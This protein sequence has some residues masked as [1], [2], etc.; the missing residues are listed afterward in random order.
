MRGQGVECSHIVH[1]ALVNLELNKNE[2]FGNTTLKIFPRSSIK[3]I[4]AIPLI[5]TG[6]AEYFQVT[7]SELAIACA[8]H[9]GEYFHVEIVKNWLNKINLTELNFECGTHSPSDPE[10]FERLIQTGSK[11]S[12]IHNNCSGKHTG[13]LATALYLNES[14]KG[15]TH[16]HHQVQK[17]ITETL[18]FFYNLDPKFTISKLLDSAIDGCSMPTFAVPLI[19]LAVAMA[20]FG[21]CE[22]LNSEMADITKKVLS[23]CL[24]NPLI[25]SGTGQ[26]CSEIM[27][28]LSDY[29]IFVKGGAE[30]VLTAILPE[31]KIGIAIKTQDGQIRASELVLSHLFY[32]L[33]LL[34]EDSPFLKP[35][36]A[37]WSK[38]ETGY[39]RLKR[40]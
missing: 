39:L 24:K 27:K 33:G 13:M 4:Q 6:A 7:D 38:L 21:S 15:Y 12:P 31:L 35:V 9:R 30:G 22:K 32:R 17:R 34:K 1:A 37:N 23:A 28:T 16:S 20:Y 40:Q 3:M 18:N 29:K 10:S 19:N 8:S 36:L 14:L 11:A 2:F 5:Q 26:Y 25:T